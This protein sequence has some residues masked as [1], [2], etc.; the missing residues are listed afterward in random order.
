MLVPSAH[1]QPS[2][3]TM[4]LKLCDGHGSV[5]VV[6]KDPYNL[7]E[8]N[9]GKEILVPRALMP[10]GVCDW[11][12]ETPC[13]I[14]AWCAELQW[15]DGDKAGAF[16]LIVVGVGK[17]FAIRPALLTPLVGALDEASAL[18]ADSDDEGLEVAQLGGESDGADEV[19]GE[20]GEDGGGGEEADVE[21]LGPTGPT[22]SGGSAADLA[23]AI[24]QR[25]AELHGVSATKQARQVEYIEGLGGKSKRYKPGCRPQGWESTAGDFNKAYTD[26]VP[27]HLR[28]RAP[29]EGLRLKRGKAARADSN[30]NLTI[31]P[32]MSLTPLMTPPLTT[33]A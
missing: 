29:E 33:L 17:A 1:V 4:M 25:T 32:P 20:E 30:P 26:N 22:S 21:M 31:T 19:Q 12:G 7:V 10:V 28:E 23:A 14:L 9:K 16:I 24:M 3:H 2:P 8:N 27:K 6:C 15:R 13:H 5:E 18:I 11:A